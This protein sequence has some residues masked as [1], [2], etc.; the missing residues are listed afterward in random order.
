MLGFT[1]ATTTGMEHTV[2]TGSGNIKIEVKNSEL[3]PENHLFEINF[4]NPKDSVR[5]QSYSLIDKTDNDTLYKTGS[6]LDGPWYRSSWKRT[7][8]CH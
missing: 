7:F 5:A 8:A 3:V 2:G 1:A 6:D 4:A